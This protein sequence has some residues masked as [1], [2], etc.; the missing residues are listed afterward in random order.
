M[1]TGTFY[2]LGGRPFAPFMQVAN[3]KENFLQEM[4]SCDINDNK[5][6]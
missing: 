3:L 4:N 2:F 5:R 6:K 1:R